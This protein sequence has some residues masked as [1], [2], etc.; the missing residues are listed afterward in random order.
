MSAS[1]SADVVSPVLYQA[2]SGSKMRPRSFSFI[3]LFAHFWSYF[4][5]LPAKETFFF[6][7]CIDHDFILIYV[8]IEDRA[9]NEV[10]IQQYGELL[11]SQWDARK[12]RW[13][14]PSMPSLLM[15]YSVDFN[16]NNVFS[17]W[18]ATRPYLLILDIISSSCYQLFVLL[19]V[20][21]PKLNMMCYSILRTPRIINYNIIIIITVNFLHYFWRRRSRDQIDRNKREYVQVLRMSLIS[22][23]D[24]PIVLSGSSPTILCDNAFIHAPTELLLIWTIR[25]TIQSSNSVV[26]PFLHGVTV[27]TRLDSTSAARG[28]AGCQAPL[29]SSYIISPVTLNLTETRAGEHGPPSCGHEWQELSFFF[30]DWPISALADSMIPRQKEWGNPRTDTCRV[31]TNRRPW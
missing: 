28:A 31:A 25:S 26:Y 15:D 27:E 22:A 13:H 6:F 16:F 5:F 20:D 21:P 11:N 1:F 4:T 19:P 8:E 3:F 29:N 14:T 24:N 9:W 17:L 10:K 7:F 12:C 23:S 30:R 18:N 2:V